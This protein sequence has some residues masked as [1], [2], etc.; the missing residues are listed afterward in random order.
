VTRSFWNKSM[1]KNNL[2]TAFTISF[3]TLA[4]IVI[5]ILIYTST[6]IFFRCVIDF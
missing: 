4:D 1:R 2:L 3:K 5:S 6:S